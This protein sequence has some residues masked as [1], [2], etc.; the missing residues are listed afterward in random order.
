MYQAILILLLFALAIIIYSKIRYKK[1]KE[2]IEDDTKFKMDTNYSFGLGFPK[3]DE[4]A[5]EVFTESAK[6]GSIE[7][8]A[9]LGN[10]HERGIH[11][12]K[13]Y[14]EAYKWYQLAADSKHPVATFALARFNME[15][16]GIPKDSDKA[17]VFLKNAAQLDYAE[18][19]MTLGALYE[20]G[21]FG[22]KVDRK[23]ALNWYIKAAQNGNAL[24]QMKVGDAYIAGELISFDEEKGMEYLTKA[25]EQNH[26]EAIRRLGLYYDRGLKFFEKNIELAFQWY[27]KGAKEGD[28]ECAYSVGYDYLVGNGVEQNYEAAAKWLLNAAE[29]GHE[30]AEY[31]VGI[32]YIREIFFE[33]NI[34]EA[35]NWLKRAADKGN[36]SAIAELNQL[37]EV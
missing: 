35:K 23:E 26:I 12:K 14:E 21:E 1:Q 22:V 19:Q 32:M 15:G 6:N 36:E 3:M 8:Y 7:A 2:G 31:T 25:A 34:D 28:I 13:D 27:L 4:L 9:A 10:M 29:C 5:A 33:K 30:L 16:F 11:F 20:L 17:I 37:E 18:A 24:A